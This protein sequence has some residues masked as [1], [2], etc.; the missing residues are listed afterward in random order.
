MYDQLT[1]YH[2][3]MQIHKIL[4]HLAHAV[5]MQHEQLIACRVHNELNI[6]CSA[7][8]Q[9]N[10]TEYTDTSATDVTIATCGCMS[11]HRKHTSMLQCFISG[12]KTTDRCAC[13]MPL[14]HKLVAGGWPAAASKGRQC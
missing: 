2:V 5:R 1:A 10:R 13:V 8:N 14:L 6:H 12:K 4:P 9:A 7:N 11:L 3:S